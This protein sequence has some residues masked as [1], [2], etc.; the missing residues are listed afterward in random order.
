MMPSK[1]KQV[2]FPFDGLSPEMLDFLSEVQ[3]QNS[4]TWYEE[5]KTDYQQYVLRPMQGL[6]AELA[7]FMLEIDPQFEVTPAVNK[8]ISRIYRDIRF[9]KE[10]LLYRNNIWI[11]FRRAIPD[12]KDTPVYFFE[13]MPGKYRYGMGYYAASKDTMDRFRARI[14]AKPEEFLAA[15]AFSRTPGNPFV[16]EGT[17]YKRPQAC[18][19]SEENREWY[20]WKDFYITCNCELGERLFQRGLVDDLKTGFAALAPFYHFLWKLRE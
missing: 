16:V 9:S 1:L 17:R 5:H 13:I 8:T 6:V 20:Q 12:W 2:E 4:K 15:T 3:E 18:D 11:T 19:K 10:K 7:S 14:E